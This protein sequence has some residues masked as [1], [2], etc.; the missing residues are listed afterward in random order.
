MRQVIDVAKTMPRPRHGERAVDDRSAGQGPDT[1]AP[2][3]DKPEG[4]ISAAMLSAGVGALALGVLT[5]LA[6]AS[7]GLKEWLTWSEAVGPLSGKTGLASIV[8]LVAWAALHMVLR[9][10]PFETRRTLVITLILVGLG[11]VGTFPVFFQAFAS[12]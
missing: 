9:H 5:T 11:M 2:Y 8:W 6:E 4:P 12:D 10:R 1:T 7:Q 3:E